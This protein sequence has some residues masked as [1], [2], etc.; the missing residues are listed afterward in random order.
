MNEKNARAP[1]EN[2][3]NDVGNNHEAVV[4]V[5]APSDDPRDPL[6]CS[7]SMAW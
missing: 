2:E 5:P 1:S 4:L 7:S 6:V 3:L